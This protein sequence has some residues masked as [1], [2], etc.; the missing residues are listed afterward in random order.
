LLITSFILRISFKFI[1]NYAKHLQL[2]N[3]WKHYEPSSINESLQKVP[4]GKQ[5]EEK[6]YQ[7]EDLPCPLKTKQNEEVWKK[8]KKL[9]RNLG[10]IKTNIDIV[11]ELL[12]PE[13]IECE[14]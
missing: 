11:K 13:G 9:T 8:L 12:E 5:A 6:V 2:S 14:K 1:K 3:D 4:T 7:P 10:A